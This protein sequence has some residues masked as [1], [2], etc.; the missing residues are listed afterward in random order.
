MKN[1]L[2]RKLIPHGVALL[3]F[4]IVSLFFSRPALEGK[5]LQQGDIIGAEG[6]AK[7]AFDWKEKHGRLA[8][9]NTNLFSG[10][11][12]YQVA[13]EGPRILLNWTKIITF[14]L[15]KPANFF[16]LACLCFYILAMAFRV[17]PVIG[18]LGALAYAFAT[19]NPIIIAAGHDTKMMA[20]A[21]APAM[22][23]GLV[24]IYER[25]YAVGVAV[26]AFYG[27]MEV[28]VNHPQIN[29]YVLLIAGFMTI[30]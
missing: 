21:Y 29:Y 13:I 3:V 22:L 2:L 5:V 1:G 19:Y 25:K 6:M 9:W 14:G 15:P 12:N 10:M 7:N 20:I 18:V 17:R 23:A 11:P 26:M 16:F 28:A 30:S 24:W 8:L 4:L 27:T